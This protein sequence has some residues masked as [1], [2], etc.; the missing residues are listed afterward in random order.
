VD[1]TTV[2]VKSTDSSVLVGVT[3]FI[4]VPSVD[5]SKDEDKDEYS[6]ELIRFSFVVDTL[7]AC[8]YSIVFSV[9]PV[10]IV[11]DAK[12]NDSVELAAVSDVI[13]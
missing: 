10:R 2:E 8:V 4:V 5:M 13:D 6:F 9:V 1:V 3:V 7:G 12:G 11:D